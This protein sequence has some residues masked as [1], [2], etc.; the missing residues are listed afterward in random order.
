MTNTLKDLFKELGISPSYTRMRIYYYL[1]GSEE[2]PTVDMIYKELISELPTLSK[3]TVYNVINLYIEKGLVSEVNIGTNEKRYELKL[4]KHSH[5]IC[6]VCKGIYDIPY[7]HRPVDTN[8]IPGFEI[9]DQE[10]NLK[11]ICS[12]CNQQ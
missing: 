1:E 6:Q 5:F 2:H 10:V 3:T 8:M 9:L 4:E 7:I 12:K 11:G